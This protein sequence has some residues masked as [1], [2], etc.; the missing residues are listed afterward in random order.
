MEKELRNKFVAVTMCL[1]CLLFGLFYAV[2]YYYQKY[3]FEQDTLQMVQWLTQ[4]DVLLNEKDSAV[5]I[6]IIENTSEYDSI[7]AMIVSGSGEIIETKYI[8]ESDR[9]PVPDRIIQKILSQRDGKWKAGSYIYDTKQL[10]GGQKLLVMIDTWDGTNK[11][12]KIITSVILI[13]IGVF[14][15]LMIT[16]YLSRFVTKPAKAAMEREKQFISDASHELKTPLGAISINAQALK[17]QDQDNKHIGNI[18]SESER[19]NRLIERLLVLSKL[20]ENTEVQKTAVSLSSCIEEMALTYESVAYD[21]GI[22]YS[23]EI[24][25]NIS[26]YANEDD[27]RQLTAILI[28]NAIKHTDSENKIFISLSEHSG[29][30]RLLVENTG[31]GISSEDIPHIFERF[32]KADTARSDNSFGLGLA[33]AKAVTERNG[34]V[35]SVQSENSVTCFTVEFK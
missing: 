21:K 24:A 26:F 27:I 31:S 17:T 3:W 5:G 18:I 22:E 15:L 11:I 19:M 13:C 34:G 2:N 10:P 12:A 14:I 30:I 35:I 23:Y 16:V 28:D 32:Y 6:D 9:E 4:S 7:I 1:M 20:D 29:A 33:I 25:E 8:I